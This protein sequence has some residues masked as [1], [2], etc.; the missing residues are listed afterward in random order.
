MRPIYFFT[1]W[2]LLTSSITFADQIDFTQIIVGDEVFTHLEVEEAKQLAKLQITNSNLTAEEKKRQI[3]KLE[4]TVADN[5][6]HGLLLISRAKQLKLKINDQQI[7]E[8]LEKLSQNNPNFLEQM[9]KENEDSAEIR[10][11]IAEELLKEQLLA[12]EVNPSVQVSTSDALELCLQES[13][14]QK[15]IDLYQI[16]IRT[17]SKPQVLKIRQEILLQLSEGRHIGELAKQF[18]QAPSVQKDSGLIA[19]IQKGQILPA[20]DQ[21]AFTLRKKRT[22]PA[23]PNPIRVPSVICF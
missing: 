18:S 7:E 11:K 15:K 6:I 8:R 23:Y 2:S 12:R 16:L 14:F 10:E 22:Q 1:L 21:A 19:N 20:L 5:L 9:K 4:Q 3:A 13:R 17:T